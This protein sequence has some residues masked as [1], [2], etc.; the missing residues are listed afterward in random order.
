MFKVTYTIKN[1]N[2]YVVYKSKSFDM[3]QKAFKFIRELNTSNIKM[4]GKP[5]IERI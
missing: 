5:T 2:G 3:L 4:I 1:D